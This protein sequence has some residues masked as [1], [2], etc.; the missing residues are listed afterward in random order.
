M[1][2]HLGMQE[3]INA[4]RACISAAVREGRDIRLEGPAQDAYLNLEAANEWLR[5]NDVAEARREVADALDQLR[6]H[7][8]YPVGDRTREQLRRAITILS[9]VLDGLSD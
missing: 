9:G 4:A 5:A 8:D 1:S 6:A 3:D 2:D 7:L